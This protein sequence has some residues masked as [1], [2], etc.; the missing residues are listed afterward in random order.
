M[1]KTSSKIFIAY[2]DSDSLSA[3]AKVAVLPEGMP[4]IPNQEEMDAINFSGFCAEQSWGNAV[5]AAT[6]ADIIIVSLSGRMDLPVPVRRWMESWPKYEQ[7]NHTTLVV[8]FGAEPTDAAKQN[9]LISYFQQIAENHGLDFRC[10]CD[11]AKQFPINPPP[12]ERADPMEMPRAERYQA[13][14][15]LAIPKAA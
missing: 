14:N 1:L 10:H 3:L 12:S 9:V 5:T 13:F 7:I 6:T 8:V 2:E 4:R 11:G 15:L